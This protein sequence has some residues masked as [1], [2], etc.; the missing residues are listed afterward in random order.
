MLWGSSRSLMILK[1]KCWGLVMLTLSLL[2]WLTRSCWLRLG[3]LGRLWCYA[4]ILMIWLLKTPKLIW[5]YLSWGSSLDSSTW[6]ATRWR[7]QR[8]YWRIYCTKW[9]IQQILRHPT[10]CS[11]KCLVILVWFMKLQ[12]TQWW[13]RCTWKHCSRTLQMLRNS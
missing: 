9:N 3:S 10:S 4:W 8:R 1:S 5:L 6:N 12:R 7:R 13:C 2:C 11:L